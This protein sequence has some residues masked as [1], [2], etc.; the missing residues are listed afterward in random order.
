MLRCRG[1]SDFLNL[2]IELYG[3]VSPGLLAEA[4]AILEEVPRRRRV[5]GAWLDAQQLAAAAQQELDHYRRVAPELESRVE[6]REGST[7]L[8]VSNGDLLIA[9]TARVSCER[10]EALLHHEV[11]VHIVTH[12]NGINQ[13]L[14]LLGA[15]LAGQEET[16]E[17]L[18]VLAEHLVGGLSGARLRQLAARVVAVHQMT[19]GAAFPEVHAGLV[20]AGV[21]RRQAF[22]IALR[23]F[24]SGGLTKDAVYLRGLRALVDHLAAGN[25]LDVLWLGKMPLEAEPLVA[26]LYQRG[27]LSDPLLCPRFL[28]HPFA[29]DRLASFTSVESLVEL[30]GEPS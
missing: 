13:P 23:V 24:R 17:G 10:V 5:P 26:E 4:Q 7:G 19:A 21:P 16:Q 27:A 25:R 30:I 28:D 20:D 22:T 8:M 9:P 11:G 2:S 18:A 15:G 12:V 1:S 29:R 6:V 3:A 14:R